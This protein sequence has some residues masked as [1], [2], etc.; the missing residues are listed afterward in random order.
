M[1]HTA[2]DLGAVRCFRP[3]WWLA[4]PGPNL[5]GARFGTAPEPGP[6][7]GYTW[8][9]ILLGLIADWLTSL[10]D[11][12]FGPTSGRRRWAIAFRKPAVRGLNTGEEITTM[13]TPDKSNEFFLPLELG[14]LKFRASF[15]ETVCFLLSGETTTCKS[16][17]YTE[18]RTV[19]LLKY[20]GLGKK[21]CRIC[22]QNLTL[23]LTYLE[24]SD[25]NQICAVLFANLFPFRR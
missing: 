20:I 24:L 23:Y 5:I 4:K 16:W 9:Q 15:C 6:R 10:P 21:K 22:D 1:R 18:E 2:N 8:Y 25:L 13:A 17:F 14:R 12:P 7:P 19:E 3:G 11:C